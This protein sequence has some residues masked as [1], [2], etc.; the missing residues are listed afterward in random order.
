VLTLLS[1]T[2]FCSDVCKPDPRNESSASISLSKLRHSLVHSCIVSAEYLVS[3]AIITAFSVEKTSH[4]GALGA[5]TSGL[6]GAAVS[7]ND[8]HKAIVGAAGSASTHSLSDPLS[9]DS[10]PATGHVLLCCKGLSGLTEAYRTMYTISVRSASNHSLNAISF[11]DCDEYLVAVLDNLLWALDERAL[12]FDETSKVKEAKRRLEI[13]AS[14]L[15]EE[16]DR[17]AEEVVVVARKHLFLSNNLYAICNYMKERRK[18]L[19][20]EAD[21]AVAGLNAAA[22]GSSG[23]VSSATSVTGKNGGAVKRKPPTVRALQ[24][25]DVFAEKVEKRSV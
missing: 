24:Q 23:A 17:A 4:F 12:K 9:C 7:S 16:D 14:G 13:N 8:A 25:T 6:A 22:G 2:V 10:H 19:R 3:R 21:A 1:L 5:L 18:E 20:A 15:F 11:A